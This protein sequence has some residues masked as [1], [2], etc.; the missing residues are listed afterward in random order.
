VIVVI[1]CAA[2]KNSEAGHLATSSG[3]LVTFVAHPE[4]A[5]HNPG[6]VYA[7]P[8]DLLEDGSSWRQFLTRYNENTAAN[9]LQL[10][11]AY[12][13]YKN[14]IYR[15]LVGRL[16]PRSVYILSAGWGLIPADYLL[17]YYDITFSSSAKKYKRRLKTDRYEDF[18]LLPDH[19]E[20][21]IVFFGGMD[22]LP[23]FCSLTNTSQDRRIVFFNSRQT[24]Q[25]DGCTFRRFE[26]TRRINWPYDCAKAFLDGTL[27]IRRSRKLL[28][29]GS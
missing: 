14:D 1:Q 9:P 4:I 18:R 11:P 17:P 10:Y 23:L 20:K 6:V 21:R 22:Y 25:C 19:T 24:S 3:K 8:D 28:S 12:R 15:A 29:R 26:A 5:P 13:L 27:R 16:G 2:S 7:R